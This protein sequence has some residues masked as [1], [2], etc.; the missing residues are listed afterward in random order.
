MEQVN[1]SKSALLMVVTATTFMG[2]FM[3]SGVN[4]ILP[5]IGREFSISAVLLSWVA[6]AYLLSTA[7]M[8]VPI[9][10]IADMTGRKKYLYGESGCSPCQPF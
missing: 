2:P 5:A 7:V 9:A 3:V 8:L 1:T 10:K 4:I 6:N